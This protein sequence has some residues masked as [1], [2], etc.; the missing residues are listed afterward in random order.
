MRRIILPAWNVR[1][2][3]RDI[4][5]VWFKRD[6]R[7]RDHAALTAAAARGPVLCLYIHEPSL[8]EAPDH[9]P[10]HL[11][12]VLE[13]LDDLTESLAE[14]G[15]VLHRRTGEVTSVLAAIQGELAQSAE[16]SRIT[17]IWAHEETTGWLAY[18]RDRTV[19]QWCRAHGHELLE[20]PQTGVVRR[21]PSRDGWATAWEARMAAAPLPAPRRLSSVALAERDDAASLA[22]SAT[23]RHSRPRLQHGGEQV[24]RETL[25][26][27]LRERGVDYRREMSSPVTA[28]DACSRLSAW[29]S[30]G[31][32]SIRTCEHAS[33]ARLQQLANGPASGDD[34]DAR[35][36]ASISSFRSRLR[37]HCHF[38]QKLEDQPPLEF[39]TMC[40]A[41][42]GLRDEQTADA[43]RLSVWYEGH[44]GYPLIDACMRSVRATGWLPFRMRAMVMSFASYH[45]W[46]HWRFTGVLLAREFLDFEPGIHYSQCQMQSGVTGINAIRIYNPV[47]Q[48]LDHDPDGTFIREWVPELAAV[49]RAALAE[50]HSMPPMLQQMYGVQ[51]GVTYP[52]PIVDNVQAMRAARDRIWAVRRAPGTVAAARRVYD[53][54]G[55]R[56]QP[57]T[58]RDT[59]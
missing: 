8:M 2:R 19:R 6:L 43:E 40:D 21:L 52:L 13:C 29:L 56:K 47:K 31:A 48:S 54:L 34:V 3:M 39:R 7:I 5:L 20:L 45:L 14:R 4:H 44:T 59:R 51:I 57:F 49:P 22:L 41:Y 24:A 23:H 27:F 53:R 55:S 38:M 42:V 33:R 17:S 12:L 37:W 58:A 46:L 1:F 16:P 11:G 15:V 10:R 25:R 36:R 28:P 26:S 30:T 50:P 35:W 9:D 18:Q 32:I